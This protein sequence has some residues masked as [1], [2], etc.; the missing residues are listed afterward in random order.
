VEGDTH[1]QHTTTSELVRIANVEIDMSDTYLGR[2]ASMQKKNA[3]AA[4]LDFTNEEW[5]SLKKLK[6]DDMMRGTANGGEINE[7]E[8]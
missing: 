6:E 2:Y 4:V 7:E 3:V 8:V 5:E 1:E